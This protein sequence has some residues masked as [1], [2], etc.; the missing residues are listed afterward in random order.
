[1]GYVEK[2]L[3]PIILNDTILQFYL[4]T[5]NLF[6]YNILSKKLYINKNNKINK[7]QASAYLSSNSHY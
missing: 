1:M 3:I 7:G 4:Y 6:N 5:G 2:Q